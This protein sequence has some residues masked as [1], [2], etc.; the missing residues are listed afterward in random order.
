MLAPAARTCLRSSA[1]KATL[2]G[3]S[4]ELG[5]GLQRVQPSE[6]A[7]GVGSV[8]H[9]LARGV[10]ARLAGV[11]RGQGS[12]LAGHGAAVGIADGGHGIMLEAATSPPE[13]G[14]F[15]HQPFISRTRS[16]T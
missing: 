1:D 14:G 9:R 5:L 2:D 4:V 7:V 13:P 12:G 3:L 15:A 8:D 10:V 11:E 16:P 6:L